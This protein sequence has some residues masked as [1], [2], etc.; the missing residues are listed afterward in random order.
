MEEGK[1]EVDRSQAKLCYLFLSAPNRTRKV[2]NQKRVPNAATL[3]ISREAVNLCPSFTSEYVLYK[4]N[5]N[6]HKKDK[7]KLT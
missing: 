4:R 3:H 7:K 2:S 6:P 1:E 5:R